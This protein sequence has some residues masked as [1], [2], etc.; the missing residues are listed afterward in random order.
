[1]IEIEKNV[2]IPM[3]A[4]ERGRIY[5]FPSMDVG[6]SFFVPNSKT[7]RLNGSISA[8]KKKNPGVKFI[9]RKQGDGIRCWRIE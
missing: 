2:P 6:D 4:L 5:P 3:K 7:G 8:F 1:M 9:V